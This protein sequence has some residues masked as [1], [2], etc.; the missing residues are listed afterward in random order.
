MTYLEFRDG[1]GAGLGSGSRGRVQ[2]RGFGPGLRPVN[3]FL[4]PDSMDLKKDPDT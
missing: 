4:D 1:H 3:Y 2:V